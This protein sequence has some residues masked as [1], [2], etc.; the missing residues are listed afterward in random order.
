MRQ[1]PACYHVGLYSTFANGTW[2]EGYCQN[3]GFESKV[4]TTKKDPIPMIHI[5]R[6]KSTGSNPQNRIRRNK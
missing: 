2:E 3:C 6:P 5:E 1:C 4:P